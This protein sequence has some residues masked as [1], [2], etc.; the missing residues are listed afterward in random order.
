MMWTSTQTV[1]CRTYLCTT[2]Q[3]NPQLTLAN[4]LPKYVSVRL[5][6]MPHLERLVCELKTARAWLTDVL[7]NPDAHTC[8]RYIRAI[9]RV[10][11]AA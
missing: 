11:V 2:P 9:I 5:L 10:Q 7:G 6:V 3:R 8:R 4:H 1:L